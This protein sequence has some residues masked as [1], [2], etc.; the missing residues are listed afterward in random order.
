[1]VW[2]HYEKCLALINLYQFGIIFIQLSDLNK[3]VIHFKSFIKIS[4]NSYHNFL[5][6]NK[7]K[8]H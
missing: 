2:Y 4:L 5:S 7:V 1:M 3:M 8:Y 6:Q